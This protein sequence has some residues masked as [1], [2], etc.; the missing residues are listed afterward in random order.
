[1]AAKTVRPGVF[2]RYPQLA[3]LRGLVPDELV[4]REIGS[5]ADEFER[6]LRRAAAVIPTVRLRDV[7]PPE[8]EAGAIHLANF[9]AH[10]GN[11]SSETVGKICLLVRSLRPR[12]IRVIGTCA[13]LTTAQ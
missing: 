4:E 13:R 2:E 9:L 6:T 8:I 7:L 11:V 10:C 1:M 3:T 5:R 12:R